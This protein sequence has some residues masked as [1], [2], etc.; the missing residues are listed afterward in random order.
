MKRA[1]E[2]TGLGSDDRESE[3]VGRLG[4]LEL[5]DELG[6]HGERALAEHERDDRFHHT[7]ERKRD[8]ARWE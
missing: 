6:E 5:L 2:L 8:H 7:K 1:L 4:D 3:E